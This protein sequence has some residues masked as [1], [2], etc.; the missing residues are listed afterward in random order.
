MVSRPVS[1]MF[2]FSLLKASRLGYIDA[3]Y[4]DARRRAYQGILKEFIE[5]DKE[6][7]VDIHIVCQV[8]GLG[9]DQERGER[10][11]E[12]TFEYYVNEKI[13][14]ND[15]KGV[16]PFIFASLEMERGR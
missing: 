11:R 10:Y 4:R 2:S 7:T 6:G 1:T 15:P 16:G 5:V 13:R 9:G 3:K 14:T 12:G 8:A